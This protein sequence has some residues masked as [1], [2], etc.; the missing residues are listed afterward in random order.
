IGVLGAGYL[1][2]IHLSLLKESKHF[3]LV[4]F[5]DTKTQIAAKI[6][7]EF[8]YQSFSD[9]NQLL[10]AVDV[11]DIVTPTH[12]HF[13]LA[14]KALQNG[15]HVFLEKPITT[16][17]EQANELV[18]L[19]KSKGLLGMVGQV[20]RFNPAFIAAHSYI[21]EPKFIESHRLAEFN[22][23][24]TD[25][26]VILDLMIHDIDAILSVVKSKVVNVHA[27]GVS[28]ISQT[29]DI[30]N[31]RLQFENGCVAN[32]TASR[33]SLK[34]MRKS[35][36]FQKDAYVS[37]DYFD[38]KVEIVSMKDAP[39]TPEDFAMIL[40]NA[41]GDEKQIFFD[42]P[43]VQESNAILSELE[44]FADAIQKN[45]EPLVSLQAGTS[46]L[47]VAYQI[48]NCYSNVSSPI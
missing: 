2:K 43:E 15:L 14:K 33:I 3:D 41:E 13:E 24:G 8:G 25:V 9:I 28:V 35:R 34:T 5:Y 48:I 11:V 47:E 7:R 38:K 37:V 29:P 23:R 31:A 21:K 17:V 40:K 10:Q 30:A 22:P 36:F 27:N 32:L 26:S 18:S 20:E 12:T 6:S 4:G 44:S 42:N 16:T 1:G 46:A 45:K 39:K 19:A